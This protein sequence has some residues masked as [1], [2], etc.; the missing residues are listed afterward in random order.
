MFRVGVGA[1][2]Y[3]NVTPISDSL[4]EGSPTAIFKLR[5]A[6]PSLAQTCQLLGK[7]STD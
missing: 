1:P 5:A 6:L 3:K 7:L 2:A 4:Q